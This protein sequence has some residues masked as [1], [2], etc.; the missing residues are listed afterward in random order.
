MKFKHKLINDRKYAIFH[1]YLI[2]F[3][4]YCFKILFTIII[5]FLILNY[6]KIIHI[7]E[8]VINNNYSKIKND[9]NLTFYKKLKR[10]IRIGI[11]AYCIKN[12]GRARLT[13]ILI[14]YIYKIKIFR[15]YL[16]TKTYKEDNEYRIPYN[17]KRETINNNLVRIIM[18]KKIDILIYQLN[19][20]EEINI[21]NKL[22]NINVIFYQHSSFFYQFYSNIH[23]FL[24]TYKEYQNSKYI[25]SIIPFENYYINNKW[26]IRSI[27]MNNFITYKYNSIIASDLSSK[28][29]LMIGRGNNRLK[30]FSIGI[31]SMEYIIN[32]IQ[33]CKM[34]IISDLRGTFYLQDI[35]NNLNLEKNVK[36]FGYSLT[37]EINFKNASLHIFPSISESF[38][39][40]LSESKIFGIPNILLGLD[41]V[42]ISK[43]GTIIIYDDTPES[44]G[45]EA[46]KI[47]TNCKYKKNLGKEAR[48]SMRNFNNDLL[49]IDWIKL[50]LSIQNGDLYYQ[51]LRKNI[52][53]NDYFINIL[54]NQIDLIKIRKPNYPNITINDLINFTK[55]EM[56][57]NA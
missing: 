33:E 19:Y 29:I 21:L 6:I 57:I 22:K 26:G 12:G 43:G 32:H 31:Q 47:L 25:V 30:R 34:K 35:I 56:L 50:F 49:F 14:N 36:F 4:L 38:G 28:I 2:K 23:T 13:A 37:P 15:I 11:Y 7:Y 53:N 39:L 41:Y 18:K 55:F 42:S 44:I 27:L 48:K 5:I 45:R 52:K 16:F 20:Y 17:I 10:K 24:D 54:K 51:N 40:V 9:L 1:R 8:L 46:I 3:Y